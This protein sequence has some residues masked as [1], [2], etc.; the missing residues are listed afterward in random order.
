[1]LLVYVLCC[2]VCY[3]MCYA[4]C[5]A[6]SFYFSIYSSTYVEQFMVNSMCHP[7]SSFIHLELTNIALSS[8]GLDLILCCFSCMAPKRIEFSCV[9]LWSV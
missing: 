3:A 4:M 8:L 7:S 2:A 1:M 5:Y 9:P 6:V